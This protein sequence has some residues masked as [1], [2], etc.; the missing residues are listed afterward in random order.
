MSQAANTT[1]PAG[2]LFAGMEKLGPGDN[3]ET[4]RMLHVLPRRS[5]RVVVDAGC[6][7]GRQTLALARELQTLVHAVDTC[8]PFLRELAQRARA[9]DLQDLVQCHLLDMGDIARVFP[10]VDLLW[11][12]GAAYNIGL[13]NA[14]AA[15]AKALVPGGL[16]VVSELTWLAPQP[17]EVVRQFFESA[18]PEM[19]TIEA[20]VAIAE[21]AGYRVL[22][23][24]TLPRRAWVE[25]YYELLGPRAKKLL[26]HPEPSVCAFAEETVREVEIFDSD[27]GSYGYVFYALERL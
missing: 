20:N 24:H 7:T 17:P 4:L 26:D 9:A 23:K 13:A 18:Y 5:F 2:L 27:D 25:G 1:D 11:S 21:D 19:K 22:G 15:W 16:A 6:G 12:E 14:L 3:A 8:E 10:E